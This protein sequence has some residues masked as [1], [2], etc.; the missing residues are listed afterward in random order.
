[1]IIRVFYPPIV[2]IG[3]RMPTYPD[4]TTWR[5]W[6]NDHAMPGSGESEAAAIGCAVL[7]ASSTSAG[8]DDPPGGPFRTALVTSVY[9]VAC[10]AVGAFVVWAVLG[11]PPIW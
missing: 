4:G 5:A 7:L 2:K 1:M 8:S 11:Y 3:V 6:V 9:G 10:M